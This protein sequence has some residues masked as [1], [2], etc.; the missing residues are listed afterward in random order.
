MWRHSQGSAVG[1]H[2][3]GGCCRQSLDGLG[4][5][6]NEAQLAGDTAVWSRWVAPRPMDDHRLHPKMQQVRSRHQESA[7]PALAAEHR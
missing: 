4:F 1:T 5:E 6:R 7:P 2:V 3:S